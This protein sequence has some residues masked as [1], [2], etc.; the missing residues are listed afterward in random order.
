M[1]RLAIAWYVFRITHSVALLGLIG[2][3]GQIPVLLLS[4]VAA[5]IVDSCSRKHLFMATQVNATLQALALAYLYRSHTLTI[6]I[7]VA[8]GI[9][10]GCNNAIDL[11]VRPALICSMAVKPALSLQLL[12][13]DS[14]VVNLCRLIGP[15]AGGIVLAHYGEGACFL[16]DA[17]SYAP[18]IA[19]VLLIPYGP[20]H[21]DTRRERGHWKSSL[22]QK[23][24]AQSLVALC[25]LSLLA[26]PY[27]VVLPMYVSTVLRRGPE[28]LGILTCVSATSAILCTAFFSAVSRIL[29]VS[30][31]NVVAA[32]GAASGLFILAWT[33]TLWI[34]VFAI[35]ILSYSVMLQVCGTNVQLQQN[36]VNEN[37]GAASALYSAAFWGVAP[38]GAIILGTLGQTLGLPHALSINAIACLCSMFVVRNLKISPLQKGTP[39]STAERYS[40]CSAE[41]HGTLVASNARAAIWRGNLNSAEDKFVAIRSWQRSQVSRVSLPAPALLDKGP[42]FYAKEDLHPFGMLEFRPDEGRSTE[43]T[44]RLVSGKPV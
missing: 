36:A 43:F 6:P 27:T 29:S 44:R 4:P 42:R 15:T 22:K 33:D 10:R 7:L 28:I 13:W 31:R 18:S 8:L 2:F 21:H 39:S 41:E 14:L 5:R 24:A 40:R 23:N 38:L 37:R 12:S 32:A 30:Q 20:T 17:L 1:T 9:L 3:A 25:S 34:A 35:A 19:C 16:I 26:L 11:P